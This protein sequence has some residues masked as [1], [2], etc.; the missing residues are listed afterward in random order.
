[1]SVTAAGVR[2]R[3]GRVRHQG[4][5]RARPRARARPATREPVAAAGVFTSNLA[6]CRAGAGERRAPREAGRP[7]RSCSTPAT[8]TRRPARRAAPTPVACASWSPTDLGCAPEHVLVCSTGLIGI[9]LPMASIEAGVP[10][11]VAGLAADEVAGRAAAGRDP[12]HRHGPQGGPRRCRAGRRAGLHGRRHGQG[13]GDA[14]ARDGDDA[15][16]RR[17]RRRGRARVPR[18]PRSSTAST[19]RSTRCVVDACT[20]TNDTVLLLANGAAGHEPIDAEGTR[21]DALVEAVTEVCDELACADGGRRRG[22]HEARARR[23]AG[24][25]DRRRRAPRGP[26]GRREP[27][28]A[29]L[30]VRRRPVLGS[31]PVGAR[32]E[33]RVVRPRAGRD[34]LQRH[35]GVPRRHRGRCTTRRALADVMADRDI[36]IV[37]DLREGMGQAADALHRPHPRLHR[38][39]HGDDS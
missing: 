21:S 4:S 6:T 12:D 34:L 5:G 2:G 11:L 32:G 14:G 1:M 35:H 27:A 33:R 30:A 17:H 26:G 16:G 7:P 24:R 31:G 39:E 3:R 19:S 38:R 20:S 13:R 10:A 9:P 22:R 28:R 37:C 29:V 15:R 23:R 36:E 25:P 8:R 18:T